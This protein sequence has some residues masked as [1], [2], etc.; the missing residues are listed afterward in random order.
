VGV[1]GGEGIVEQVD[2]RV[3]VDSAGQRDALLLTAG[4]VDSFVADLGVVAFG[5]DINIGAEGAVFYYLNERDKTK[6]KHTARNK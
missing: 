3:A 4:Q 2:V 5:Q 1:D 6:Q